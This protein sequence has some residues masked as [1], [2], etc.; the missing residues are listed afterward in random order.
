MQLAVLCVVCLLP[1][2]L[3]RPL[4][5]QAGGV[6]EPEWEQA[7]NYL[8]RFYPYDSKTKIA[9]SLEDR[10]KEMQKFF[11]LPITGMLNSRIIKIM[12]KPRCGIPDIAEYSLFPN[13]PKW[14]SKVVTYRIVS[15]TRDL[16]Y[17]KVN[18]LVAKAFEM[19]SKEISLNF[20]RI[21]WGIADIMIG[22]ARGAHGDSYPFDGPGNILAHAFAPG[23][24]L[25][26]DAHFDEDERW[27]DGS[28]LGINF[29]Y[30]ATHEL[31]HSLGLGHSSDPNAVMYPTYEDKDSENFKLSQDDI[32]GIQILYGERRD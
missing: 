30:A 29:L 20:K 28:S 26:G 17:F 11:R 3:A 7:Q 8:K 19:W 13:S 6:T 23:P 18:Q 5:P 25:G 9:N 32:E 12:Q 14:T 16:S 27:T 24:G 10:L 22:F 1:G 2:G 21:R 15:Y 31:G 4:P